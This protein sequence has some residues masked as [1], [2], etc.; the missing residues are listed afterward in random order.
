MTQ[1][2]FNLWTEPWI[3]VE[4]YDGGTVLTSI[5]DV[6]LNAHTYKDIYDP[7]PLVIVGIHRLLTAI[8]Q[9]IYD[10][11]HEEEIA[12]IWQQQ[13]FATDRLEQFG[14]AYGNRFDLFSQDYPFMQSA[15]LPKHVP[16][17]KSKNFAN[18]LAYE[19]PGGSEVTHY[20]HSEEVNT[21][22]CPACA[23]KGLI[24]LPAFATAG[25]RGYGTSIAGMPPIYMLPKGKKLFHNLVLS[26][27][28]PSYQPSTNVSRQND[29][30]WWKHSPVVQLEKLNKVGYLHGLTM[31]TRRVRLHTD[32]VTG[33]C[34]QCSIRTEIG[35]YS[36][37]WGAGESYDKNAPFWSDPFVSYVVTDDGAKAIRLSSGKALWRDYATLFM[38][39]RSNRQAGILRQFAELEDY[40]SD[41]LSHESI[42][43]LRCI[44]F[45]NDPRKA[46]KLLEWVDS[47]MVIA[48]ALLDDEEATY[49][50]QNSVNFAT[51]CSGKINAIFQEAF[52][53]SKKDERYRKTKQQ[54]IDAFW[55]DLSIPFR[56]Y[57]ISLVDVDNREQQETD[58]IDT[59][60]RT[61]LK[62]FQEAAAQVGTGAH[63]LRQSVQGENRCRVALYKVR[64]DWKGA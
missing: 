54:M 44:G 29:T 52:A 22:F 43:T 63:T 42:L 32:F 16:K 49:V 12:A 60:V 8:V 33:T 36:I 28:N 35:V 47:E 53:R 27:V 41:V 23:A 46:A 39:G 50:V 56:Q 20:L 25:G 7:S 13:H 9:D 26:L 57:V 2:T 21:V 4:T 61:G 48:T 24:M 10:P 45:R 55:R 62:V 37:E 59:V 5:F 15:D 6:L 17:G 19:L 1:P 14:V 11:Q 30:V 31:P 51:E 40:H 3:T 38:R 64:K 18:R 58:W 34:M